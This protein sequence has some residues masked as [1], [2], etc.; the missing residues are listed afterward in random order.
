MN[1]RM[2][3]K[4]NNLILDL[5]EKDDTLYNKFRDYTTDDNYEERDL[6]D[7][8]MDTYAVELIIE[9]NPLLHDILFFTLDLVIWS[10]VVEEA[11]RRGW[12]GG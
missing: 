12:Y 3:D 10:D 8:L 2:Y 11:A 1:G 9:V 5:I 6:A 4:L 7:M